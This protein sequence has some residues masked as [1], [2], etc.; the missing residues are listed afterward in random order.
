MDELLNSGMHSAK[1]KAN[2]ST[3]QEDTMT[4]QTTTITT[5]KV[6]VG[7][8][9][10]QYAVKA[11]GVLAALIGIWGAACLIGGFASSGATGLAKGF[12]TALTGM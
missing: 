2:K 12:I 7:Q 9:T 8:E 11:M 5:A 1:M 4:T 6:D 10:G 3:K